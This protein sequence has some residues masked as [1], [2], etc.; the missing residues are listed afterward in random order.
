MTTTDDDGA[1]RENPLNTGST[2]MSF[3][4]SSL[5][6]PRPP[7]SVPETQVPPSPSKASSP[8]G[9]GMGAAHFGKSSAPAWSVAHEARQTQ[10]WTIVLRHR[11]NQ[12]DYFE[13]FN[14]DAAPLV[15]KLLS[16]LIQTTET[17]RK[18]KSQLDVVTQ[19]KIISLEQV[20]FIV[21]ILLWKAL[22]N[23][24]N[25]SRRSRTKSFV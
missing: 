10:D 2:R 18:F 14:D 19:E 12:L 23:W 21:C 15:Q 1:R 13:P 20:C 6:P 16:D 22:T 11:L 7:S 24:K 8:M 5:L 3:L 17:A 25:R 4:K 9:A